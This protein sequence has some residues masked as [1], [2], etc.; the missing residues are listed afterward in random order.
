MNL[1]RLLTLAV[2]LCSGTSFAKQDCAYTFSWTNPPSFSFCVTKFGTIG[3][4]Q[5]PIGTNHLDATKPV[6][7]F[8]WLISDSSGGQAQGA[9]IP[10]LGD[11]LAGSGNL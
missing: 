1:R 6:E 3:M 7:G 11:T 2:L 9:Q 8:A 4:I 5:S 10:G